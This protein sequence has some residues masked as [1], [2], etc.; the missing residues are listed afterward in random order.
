MKLCRAVGLT[1]Q[2]HYKHLR[3]VTRELLHEEIVTEFAIIRR[4]LHQGLGCKK[5]YYEATR[6]LD[7]KGIGRDKFFRIMDKAG[8]VLRRRYKKAKTTNSNHAFRKYDNILDDD[9]KRK[10][11]GAVVSDIT[12]LRAG[13]SFQYLSL[14]TEVSS[15]KIVGWDLSSSLG[16]EGSIRAVKM[17]LHEIGE[18]TGMVHHSD[19]G[20]QYCS[21][22]YIRLLEERGIRISMS[23]KGN[24]YQNAIAERVN[25]ILKGEYKLNHHF[26]K[27]EDAGKAVRE[28]IRLYNDDRPHWSLG[29][30]TPSEVYASGAK[31]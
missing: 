28:A 18:A 19:R 9:A 16:I 7:M 21:R 1:R 31:N 29:L 23:E 17:A 14:V 22:E 13:D 11:N 30:R 8:L 4:L 24:P 5:I 27:K 15:R 6:E 20:I 3:R 2:S 10:R 12:Y 26:G 25:G